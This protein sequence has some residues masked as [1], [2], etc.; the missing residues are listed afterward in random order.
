MRAKT[1]PFNTHKMFSAFLGA[2]LF[3]MASTT[4]AET[5]IFYFG[6]YASHAADVGAWKASAMASGK[7]SGVRV[8]AIPY[9]SDAGAGR[10]SAVNHASAKIKKVVNFINDNPTNR[11][12]LV[13]HSS[14]CAVS[15]AAAWKIK[16]PSNSEIVNLDGF[17]PGPKLQK[18]MKSTCWYATNQYGN[19]SRNADSMREN[20]KNTKSYQSNTC[21]TRWCLHF[22]LVNTEVI[23][24]LG[25]KT[26][27]WRGYESCSA[28]M[29][30]YN[31]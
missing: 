25:P 23:P 24:K 15:N 5:V 20:C 21:R 26:Y 10:E 30:W 7:L 16:D 12:I 4:R 8:I 22:S 14:G 18:K 11:Y 28:F 13:C 29:D 2:A 17:A 1:P 9:P 19:E 27:S 3:F 6:G 31:P